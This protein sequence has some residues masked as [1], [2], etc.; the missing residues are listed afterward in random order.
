M[1]IFIEMQTSGEQ[2]AIPPIT[3][4]TDWQEAESEFHRLCSVAAVSAVPIHTIMM[5]DE[6]GNTLRVEHFEH[7]EAK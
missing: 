7:E 4:K 2:T 3:T 5:L 1:Y 6:Y